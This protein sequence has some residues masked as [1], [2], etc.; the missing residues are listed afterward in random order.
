[1]LILGKYSLRLDSLPRKGESFNFAV[2]VN[3][4]AEN[5]PSI[6]PIYEADP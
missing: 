1:M 5:C 3:H 2:P 6:G 4:M